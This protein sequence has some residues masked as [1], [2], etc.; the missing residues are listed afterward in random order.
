MI[1]RGIDN[2]KFFFLELKY[3]PAGP[4]VSLIKKNLSLLDEAELDGD[5]CHQNCLGFATA[6]KSSGK[7]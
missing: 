5:T 2:A 7:Q 1:F 6:P 4:V 3:T